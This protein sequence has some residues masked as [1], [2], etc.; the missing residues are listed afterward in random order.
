MVM[1]SPGSGSPDKKSEWKFA[2]V[3]GDK[4]TAEQIHDEDIITA[5]EFD[6]TGKYLALGDQAGR[7]IIF[8]QPETNAKKGTFVEFQYLTELQ[9]H[10]KEF[11][12]LKS[13][14]I[15]ERINQIQWLQPQGNNLYVLT[16]NDKTIKAWKISEKILKEGCLF[17]QD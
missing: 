10:I 5:L 7:L 6:N 14:E 12:Y 15:E 17:E 2:Q 8:D 16:T 3:F 1:R 4:S 13:S 11:D 9:S